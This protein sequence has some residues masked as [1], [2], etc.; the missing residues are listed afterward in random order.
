MPDVE[1]RH[2][3]QRGSVQ[4]VTWL[5]EADHVSSWLSQITSSAQC[6]CDPYLP[7]K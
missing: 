2:V 5:P 3:D 4:Q 1:G 6:R 7:D